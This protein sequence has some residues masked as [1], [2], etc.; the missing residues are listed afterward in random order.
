MSP[1]F[2]HADDCLMFNVSHMMDNVL[3]FFLRP[4]TLITLVSL[5]KQI[6]LI[7]VLL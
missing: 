7:F 5:I 1:Y 2:I 6:H 3:L 4:S